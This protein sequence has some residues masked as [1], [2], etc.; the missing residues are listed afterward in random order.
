MVKAIWREIGED[1]VLTR[2]AALSYY[3]IFALFPMLLFITALLGML[4]ADL[5]DT[6]MVPLSRLLPTD[7]VEKTMTEVMDHASGGLLSFSVAAALWSASNGMSALMRAVTVAFDVED[8]RPWWKRQLLA[9][10]LTAGSATMILLGLLLLLFGDWLGA[11]FA[12]VEQVGAFVSVAWKIGRWVVIVMMINIAVNLIYHLS[13]P[14][15]PRW[16]PLTAGSTFAVIAWIG[17]SLVFQAALG[18]F[19]RLGTTYGSIGGTIALLLWLYY[20]GVIIFIGAEIDSEISRG[21]RA[22]A[23]VAA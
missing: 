3:F 9:V 16:R 2:A 1:D 20:S 7:V 18:T 4:R 6:L 19:I 14:T 15:R 23:P 12:S 8:H 10:G 21:R 17:M 13:L 11:R 22:A 5:F